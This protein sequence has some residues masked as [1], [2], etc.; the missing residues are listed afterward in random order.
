M[1]KT[2]NKL[3]LTP[4]SV[5]PVV[6]LTILTV[7]ALPVIDGF[8]RRFGVTNER[9]IGANWCANQLV[10]YLDQR[11]NCRIQEKNNNT[12]KKKSSAFVCVP[13]VVSSIIDTLCNGR[14]HHHWRKYMR[15]AVVGWIV[16]GALLKC[17]RSCVSTFIWLGTTI[18]LK[19]YPLWYVLFVCDVGLKLCFAKRSRSHS[20]WLRFFFTTLVKCGQNSLWH[21]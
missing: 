1:N 6:C 14:R 9:H 8:R 21:L 12:R 19:V 11:M 13:K 7:L 3:K 10:W 15:C 16:G 20:L 17:L 5:V 4:I 18:V 2:N